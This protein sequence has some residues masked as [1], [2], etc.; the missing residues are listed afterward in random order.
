MCAAIA[1]DRTKTRCAVYIQ[2]QRDASHNHARRIWLAV[3]FGL[4][5]GAAH[6]PIAQP[7]APRECD[8]RTATMI[9]LRCRRGAA[10]S[11]PAIASSH[12]FVH[13]SPASRQCYCKLIGL[14]ILLTPQTCT[15][16]VFP[17]AGKQ[18]TPLCDP[19]PTRVMCP[20][21]TLIVLQLIHK[22]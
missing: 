11:H 13:L 1:L 4:S 6:L 9:E 2:R 3:C 17:A 21:V 16:L 7:T 15:P 10:T 20:D 14:R 5:L 22:T 12:S 19:V 18:N 8:I